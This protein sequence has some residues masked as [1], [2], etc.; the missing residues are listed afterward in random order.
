MTR[1]LIVTLPDGSFC[2]QEQYAARYRRLDGKIDGNDPNGDL[3]TPTERDKARIQYSL[4]TQRLAG[5]TQ[6]VTPDESAGDFHS[7]Q[8]HSAKVALVAGELAK[9]LCRKFKKWN[10]DERHM[11]CAFGG[12]DIAACESA[13]LAHDIGHPP[14]G[15]VA[16]VMLDDFLRGQSGFEF[17]CTTSAI[18][19]EG[20]KQVRSAPNLLNGL[21]EPMVRDGFEGN[22][23]SFRT[24]VTLDSNSKAR[25]ESRSQQGLHSTG[26]NLTNVTLAAVLKYPWWR[27]EEHP[28]YNSKFGAYAAEI[29]PFIKARAWT[30]STR[31]GPLDQTVEAAIM[32]IADDLTYAIHDL[33]DFYVAGRLNLAKIK[34]ELE[35]EVASMRSSSYVDFANLSPSERSEYSRKFGDLYLSQRNFFESS[36]RDL[37]QFYPGFTNL[38]DYVWALEE[39]ASRLDGIFEKFQ[40][41]TAGIGHTIQ[42]FSRM[43]HPPID[44]IRI[45]NGTPPWK[46]GPPV[47]IERQS[48]HYVQVLKQIA[49][50]HIIRTPFVGFSQRSQKSALRRTLLGL[51]DWLRESPRYGELPDPLASFLRDPAKN[52]DRVQ[53]DILVSR[54]AIVDYLCSLTDRQV[55]E[56]SAWLAGTNLPRI[57]HTST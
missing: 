50:G 47:Y 40:R 4:Y 57:V 49:K 26:L 34:D 18:S 22:A 21:P 19:G 6:V 37:V 20:R 32:D 2:Y 5:V 31:L 45:S 16:E 36:Y 46:D 54:R 14:F 27:V 38:S 52:S 15:H 7:R 53:Y 9:D 8:S 25:D 1:P 11:I 30:E 33:Q 43:L 55:V 42:Q 3:R 35:R 48:W 17:S 29:D 24:I 28:K 10:M 56:I 12:I 23:Q 41:S 44:S 51:D 39:V 13:G